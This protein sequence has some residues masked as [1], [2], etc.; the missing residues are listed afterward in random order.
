MLTAKHSGTVPGQLTG[1]LAQFIPDMPPYTPSTPQICEKPCEACEAD[2]PYRFISYAHDDAKRVY[3]IVKNLFEA[4]WEL[5]YDE[6]I[7]TTER[8]LPVIAD[9]VKRSAMFLLMLT[10]RCLEHPL[11]MNCELEYARQLHLPI[12]PV[13]S[14]LNCQLKDA[15][16]STF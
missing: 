6:G 4:G 10:N 12:V 5:W 3:P 11:V 8:Y 13:L 14:T 1:A 2:E 15:P 16:A 7:Q 9:H